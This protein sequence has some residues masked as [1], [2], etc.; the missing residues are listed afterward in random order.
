M[1]DRVALR[2][3]TASIVWGYQEAAAV[4]RWTI[5]RADRGRPWTLSADLARSDPYRLR[6]RPLLFTAP[7]TGGFFCWPLLDFRVDRDRRVLTATVGPL[8][9]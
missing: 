6:Q 8:E 1:F 9:Y 5:V 7:R 3:A 4:G 2:G